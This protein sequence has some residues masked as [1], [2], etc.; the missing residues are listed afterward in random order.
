M[1]FYTVIDSPI[2]PLLLTSDGE[3]LTGVHMDADLSLG[4]LRGEWRQD[5]VPLQAAADQL[6]AYFAGELET[7]DLPMKAAGTTFQK[8]VWRALCD[9]PFGETVSYK[10][11]AERIGLPKA[12]RAVGLANG[13]NPIAV[14]VPCHRVI[15]ANGKLTGYGGGLPRKQWLLTH[16]N[17]QGGLLNAAPL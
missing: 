13:R 1:N 10:D 15:G 16:E 12:V 7:F 2:D 4:K 6:R 9:I 5:P 11:I 3:H 17:R 14:V 8:T